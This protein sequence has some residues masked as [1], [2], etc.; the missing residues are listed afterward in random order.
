MSGAQ[1]QSERFG[2][3]AQEAAGRSRAAVGCSEVSIV[4]RLRGSWEE[5]NSD[6]LTCL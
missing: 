6:S 5:T 1:V 4:A 3:A 2:P